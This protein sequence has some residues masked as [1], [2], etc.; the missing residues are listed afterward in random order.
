MGLYRTGVW[1]YHWVPL[2][3]FSAAAA[4]SSSSV[5]LQLFAFIFRL[6]QMAQWY[7]WTISHVKIH[8][9]NPTHCW[10]TLTVNSIETWS[11]GQSFGRRR[12]TKRN[13]KYDIYYGWF[14]FLYFSATDTILYYYYWDRFLFFYKDAKYIRSVIMYSVVANRIYFERTAATTSKLR[15]VFSVFV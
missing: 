15:S 6:W 8:L 2:S 14:P 11:A 5:F 3:I 4:V 9:S 10:G 7:K 1:K 12:Q 13:V